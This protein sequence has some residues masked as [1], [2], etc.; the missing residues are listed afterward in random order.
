MRE[1]WVGGA[2]LDPNKEYTI[3][4]K[5]YLTSGKDGYDMFLKVMVSITANKRQR[6]SGSESEIYKLTEEYQKDH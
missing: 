5:T 1:V 4:T 3:A 2:P 6:I